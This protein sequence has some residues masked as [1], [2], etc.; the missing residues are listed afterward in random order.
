MT[1]LYTTAEDR[2]LTAKAQERGDPELNLVLGS[3]GIYRT[4]EEYTDWIKQRA[5]EDK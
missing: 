2:Y 3:D 5:L 1:A 4:K